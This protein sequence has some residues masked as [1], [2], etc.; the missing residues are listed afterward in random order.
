MLGAP[1]ETITMLHHAE[2]IA[3]IPNKRLVTYET[4]VL[5]NGQR[6]WQSFHDIASGSQGAFPFEDVVSDGV[7]AFEVIAR[8]ALAAGI[9]RRDRVGLADA[10]LF[11]AQELVDFAVG[12]LTSRFA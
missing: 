8:D 6:T 5:V 7:D 9:G 2:T 12:W 11:P 3:D 4:A 10:Y 1:L